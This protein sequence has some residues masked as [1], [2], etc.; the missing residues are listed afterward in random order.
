VNFALEPGSV[1]GTHGQN[2]TALPET[3]QLYGNYPNPFNP[4]TE[5][6]FGI[7]QEMDVDIRVFDL[8]GREVNVLPLGRLSAGTHAASWNGRDRNGHQVTSG[9]YFY[10]LESAGQR[11]D[12]RKMTLLK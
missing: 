10:V 3:A 8:L 7:H 12:T 1:T 4:E 5:I 11:L 6:S 2:D 9:I